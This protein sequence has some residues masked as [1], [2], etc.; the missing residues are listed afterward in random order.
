VDDPKED[1]VQLIQ[2]YAAAMSTRDQRLIGMA[3]AALS[4][5]L[6]SIEI[7]LKEDSKE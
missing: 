7:K 2:S 4:E 1:L 3:G 6:E 5:R